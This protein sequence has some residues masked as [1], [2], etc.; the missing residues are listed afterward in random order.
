MNTELEQKMARLEA[1]LRRQKKITLALFVCAIVAASSTRVVS[2]TSQTEIVTRTLKIVGSDGKVRA[3]LSADPKVAPRGA[4]L[5]L[6]NS[7]GETRAEL[8]VD[9]NNGFVAFK[10]ASQKEPHAILGFVD[11]NSM[12]GLSA[13]TSQTRVSVAAGAEVSGLSVA[14]PN[15]KEN[16]VVEADKNGGVVRMLDAGGKVKQQWR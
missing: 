14:G 4:M 9:G 13:P 10:G 12:L 16:F 3:F 11:G 8:C 5:G 1:E 7:K 15:G 2:Q 6:L